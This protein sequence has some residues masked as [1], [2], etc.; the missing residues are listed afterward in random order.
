MLHQTKHFHHISKGGL[1]LV[2]LLIGRFLLSG[3]DIRTFADSPTVNGTII[4]GS[5][6]GNTEVSYSIVGT[7]GSTITYTMPFTSNDLRGTE[8]GW[9]LYITSTTLTGSSGTLP[10]GASTIIGTTA[11]C[12]IPGTCSTP[13]LE[14]TIKGVIAL[15]SA[16]GAPPLAVEFSEPLLLREQVHTQ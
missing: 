9:N 16:L 3:A 8:A 14:N 2:M 7:P 13:I 10:V 4:A 1:L 11:T 5:L 6:G 12:T 15:P